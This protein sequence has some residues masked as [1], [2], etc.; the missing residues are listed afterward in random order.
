MIRTSGIPQII[1]NIEF[2]VSPVDIVNKSMKQFQS[3]ITACLSVLS[4]RHSELSWYTP[5][6]T[7]QNRFYTH[8]DN[9]ALW[10]R[11]CQSLHP[12]LTQL[13]TTLLKEALLGRGLGSAPLSS[14]WSNSTYCI[15][16]MGS[17][18]GVKADFGRIPVIACH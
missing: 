13:L 4:C 14:D 2:P 18:G 10:E 15:S 17:I 9:N 11:H 12:V 6:K 7:R 1:R 3:F 5:G 16:P 8:I